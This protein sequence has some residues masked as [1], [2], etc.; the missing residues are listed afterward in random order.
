M[1]RMELKGEMRGVGREMRKV[2]KHSSK[3][4]TGWIVEGLYSK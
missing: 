2:K 1:Q 3:R 4:E